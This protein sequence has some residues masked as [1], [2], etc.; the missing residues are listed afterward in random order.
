MTHESKPQ[1]IV[2]RSIRACLMSV[3]RFHVPQQILILVRI[4]PARTERKV[5]PNQSTY[6]KVLREG[7]S[8][9]RFLQLYALPSTLYQV[10]GDGAKG[11]KMIEIVRDKGP[12]NLVR[13]KLQAQRHVHFP[14]DL[15]FSFRQAQDVNEAKHNANKCRRVPES[16][17]ARGTSHRHMKSI[18]L[19]PF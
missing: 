14:V 10:I 17:R 11:A 15:R 1:T 4:K 19:H 18:S 13:P 8:S 6:T 5:C 7:L 3:R 9:F 16:C 2:Q 12:L